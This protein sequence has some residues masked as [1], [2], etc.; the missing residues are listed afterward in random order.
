MV[1]VSTL[2]VSAATPALA[3]G[4]FA[5]LKRRGE[6]RGEGGVGEDAMVDRPLRNPHSQYTL[7]I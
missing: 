4:R 2:P 3:L 5:N 7:V 6:N 1:V